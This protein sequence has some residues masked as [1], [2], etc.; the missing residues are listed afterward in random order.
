MN[1]RLA[2]AVFLIAILNFS[3][4]TFAHAGA[5][6]LADALS[7]HGFAQ[8]LA[9]PVSDLGPLAAMLAACLRSAP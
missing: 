7:P 2:K 9:H 5:E 6:A 8:G 4:G 1:T 3:T